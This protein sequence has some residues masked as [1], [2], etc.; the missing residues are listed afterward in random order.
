M[1]NGSKFLAGVL[2]G[3][4]AGAAIGIFLTSDKGKEMMADI[5]EKAGKSTE[6]FK[7]TVKHF[8]EE[9]NDTLK[10][11]KKFVKGEEEKSPQTETP[12]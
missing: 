11:A 9:M 10:R 12:A 5:K 3:A 7:K 8:E 4:A 1:S 6:G 2:L